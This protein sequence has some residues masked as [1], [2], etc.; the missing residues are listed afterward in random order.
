M[1][2][3]LLTF[4]PLN[5]SFLTSPCFLKI[6]YFSRL[7]V[8]F[9]LPEVHG[10]SAARRKTRTKQKTIPIQYSDE[11]NQ[12]QDSGQNARRMAQLSRNNKELEGNLLRIQNQ[13]LTLDKAYTQLKLNKVM[14]IFVE[15]LFLT[16]PLKVTHII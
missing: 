2:I 6:F 13:L 3:F 4:T 9:E 15:I 10:M 7:D 14:T 1:V 12:K 11:R 5:F 8:L 16:F